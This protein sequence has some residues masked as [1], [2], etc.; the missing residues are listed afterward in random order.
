M[1]W[2]YGPKESPT[3]RRDANILETCKL[4]QIYNKDIDR[5]KFLIHTSPRAPPCVPSTQWEHILR[6]EPVD[7]EQFHILACLSGGRRRVITASDWCVTWILASKAIAFAFPHRAEELRAYGDHINMEF[8]MKITRSHSQ[9]ILS[10]IATRNIVEGG[11]R[12]LLTDTF[13]RSFI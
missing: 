4:L 11:Q 5:A 12:T 8:A 3:S 2:Y 7:L 9:I 1:P 6:G 13:P 10:D